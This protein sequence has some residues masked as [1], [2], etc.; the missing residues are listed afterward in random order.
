MV[1]AVW[2][3]VVAGCASA[4]ELPRRPSRAPCLPCVRPTFEPLG[5]ARRAARAYEKDQDE[6]PEHILAAFFS[7]FF[8]FC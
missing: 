3:S 1:R 8:F 6:P 7:F 2:A 5:H 4:P